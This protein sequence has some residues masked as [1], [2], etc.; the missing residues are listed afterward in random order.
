MDRLLTALGIYLLQ[1]L[2]FLLWKIPL[3]AVFACLTC[4]QESPEMDKD[5]YG[6]VVEKPLLRDHIISNNYIKWQEN[7]MNNFEHHVVGVAE[8]EFNRSLSVVRE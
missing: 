3:Y 7:A 1:H 4:C 2:I 6:E 8:L 5:E